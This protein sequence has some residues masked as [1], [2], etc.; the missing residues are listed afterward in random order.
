MRFRLTAAVL[1][2]ALSSIAA[3]QGT[4]AKRPI[5]VGD[6]YR[7]KNVNDPQLSPDGKWVAYT[8]TTTDSAKDKSDTDIW[9]TSWDGSQTI[10]VTSS[11]DGE[12]SPR[13]SPDGRYLA[14]ISSRQ[15]GKG[16]QLWLLDRRGGEAKRVTELKPGIRQY[17]WSPDSKR[18]ALVMSDVAPDADTT[19]KKPK[20]IVV[21]RLHFKSDAGGYLD[22]THTHIYLFDLETRQTTNLIPGLY[23][24]SEPTW[25]PDGKWIA[26]ESKRV[27]GDLDRSNNSDVYVI[28][29]RAGATPKQ[30][31]IFDG[32]DG[33]P[34]A[35]SPDGSLLAYLRGS[36]AKFSAYNEDRLTVIPA[37][38]GTPRVLTESLDR[39][40]R[41]PQFTTDGKSI[42]FMYADDRAQFIG[43]IPVAGGAVQKLLDGRRVLGAYSMIADGK[44]AVLNGTANAPSEVFA[45]EN[46]ALRQLSHQN[47]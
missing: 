35:W 24:E 36:D 11:P 42:V 21:D 1:I 7:V 40:V 43:R 46:G 13:W 6:M 9:M 37:T 4:V 19:N 25:S 20:P 22:S 32:P 41:D 3:A 14:F 45:L 23:D 33:G 38:G 39:P 16:G 15:A 18:L 2:V 28:E 10:Q 26:F 12:S 47:D 27:P 17:E 31:T 29:A 5:R 30:L 8:V 44:V 34:L